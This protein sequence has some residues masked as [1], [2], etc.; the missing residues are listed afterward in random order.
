MYRTIVIAAILLVLATGVACA[1]TGCPQV[2]E[3]QGFSTSTAISAFGTVTETD[4]VVSQITSLTGT[5]YGQP[6]GLPPVLPLAP[7]IHEYYVDA[8]SENTV[9][10]QGLATYI[11]TMTTDTA[12][13]AGPNQ[14]NL[15]AVKVVEF[16]G[17]DLGRMTSEESNT[18]DG[19]GTGTWDTFSYICPFLSHGGNFTPAFCNIVQQES[20][21][22]IT[23]GSLATEVQ[24]RHIMEIAHDAF[25]SDTETDT[26]MTGHY[27]LSDPGVKTGY[28]VTLTGIGGLPASGSAS[29]EIN[30]HVQEGGYYEGTHSHQGGRPELLRVEHG[31]RR[32]HPLLQED[33]VLPPS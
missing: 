5:A 25:I 28:Q 16:V 3:I 9:A 30:V 31:R 33:R 7:V 14:Y 2:P 24:E 29:A 15:V 32:Y 22:D 17:S 18:L 26:L 6:S 21:V 19:A 10:D 1:D 13:M 27:P 11:K 23:R 8:Y 4:N 20:S 12:G